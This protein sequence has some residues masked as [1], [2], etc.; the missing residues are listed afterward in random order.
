MVTWLFLIFRA[1]PVI[2]RIA[3]RLSRAGYRRNLLRDL[4]AALR[5]GTL[6]Q[7]EWYAIGTALG[8]FR[9]T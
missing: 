6:T 4:E 7:G 3:H 1:L 9:Q 2:A 5:D 8:V